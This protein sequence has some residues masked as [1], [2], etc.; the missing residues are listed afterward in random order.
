MAGKKSVSQR[1]PSALKRARQSAVKRLR[2]RYKHATM[3][4]AIKKLRL[5]KDKKE[6][7]KTLPTV[8]S[9]IDKVAKHHIIH[10]NKASNLKGKLYHHI[11]KL[12]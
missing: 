5:I 6:A 12:G 3:R 4:S 8:V 1:K 7:E 10:K 11:Q 2:N 9:I